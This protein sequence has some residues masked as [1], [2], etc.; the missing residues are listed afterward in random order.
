[1]HSRPCPTE[2]KKEYTIHLALDKIREQAHIFPVY[3]GYVLSVVDSNVKF[4]LGTSLVGSSFEDL[5]DEPE[6]NEDFFFEILA[7][8][9][10]ARKEIGFTHNDIHGDNIMF[11]RL[12]G[13]T[14]RVY[15]IG[16]TRKMCFRNSIQP[17]LIDYGKSAVLG[18]QPPNPKA[19]PQETELFKKSDIGNLTALFL[20]RKASDSFKGFLEKTFNTY[21]RARISS[22]FENDSAFN[23]TN[24]EDLLVEFFGEELEKCN[25]CP[26]RA[27]Y[28]EQKLGGRAFCSLECQLA[29]VGLHRR[30]V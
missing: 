1:M 14:E 29:T 2:P 28:H 30:L 19:R 23:Y 3:W 27:K 5:P 24:I 11:D 4:F 22:T 20:H 7:A 17:R 25:R 15:S 12:E 8:L 10:V 21:Q 9:Y 16:D 18:R 26:K 6:I 13:D